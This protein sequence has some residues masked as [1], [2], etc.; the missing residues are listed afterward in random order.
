MIERSR[1]RVPAGEAGE[2]SSSWSDFCV[3]SY[4]GI[5]VKD[6]K[7]PGHCAKSADVRLQLKIPRTWLRII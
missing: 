2:F 4:V 6:V 5:S 7:D 3:D 1:I